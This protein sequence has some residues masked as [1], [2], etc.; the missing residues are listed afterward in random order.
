MGK[1]DHVGGS[2]HDILVSLTSRREQERQEAHIE[3]L[4]MGDHGLA[5]SHQ[6][7]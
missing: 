3:E 6:L 1:R 4:N 5:M 2:M 7:G